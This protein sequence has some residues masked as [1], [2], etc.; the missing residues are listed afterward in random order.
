[1]DAFFLDPQVQRL[2]PEETR[3]LGLR[4]EPYPE[5]KRVRVNLE[6]TP[7]LQRPY[8][9]LILSDPEGNEVSSASIVEPVSCTLEL[10]LH[11][12]VSAQIAG[13]YRLA[14]HLSYPD[15]GEIDQ[16]EATIEITPS[17][18]LNDQSHR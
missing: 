4:A 13:T 17:A 6:L 12:R 16:R 5:G 15:L 10:T 3:I 7:F 11:L 2:P 8:I 14:A 1:M 9:E 18:E